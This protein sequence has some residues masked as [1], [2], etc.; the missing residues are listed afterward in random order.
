MIKTLGNCSAGTSEG[1]QMQ[2][3]ML[4]LKTT[5]IPKQDNHIAHVRAVSSCQESREA[6]NTNSLWHSFEV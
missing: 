4:C 1:N 3:A 5:R 2:G 6:R